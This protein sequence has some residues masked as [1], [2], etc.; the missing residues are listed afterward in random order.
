[1]NGVG[2]EVGSRLREARKRAG[3][4]Q[5]QLAE[6]AD[7]A[8]E[9]VSRVERGV[10]SPTVDNLQTMARVLG[11]SL[12]TLVGEGGEA[13]IE[14][15]PPEVGRI[16]HVL[17]EETPEQQRRIRRIVELILACGEEG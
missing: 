12:A 14:Q 7:L 4:T 16:V 2:V 5:T 15:L 17:R 1:M 11:T 6:A 13:P 10:Q 8:L 9:T 3:L